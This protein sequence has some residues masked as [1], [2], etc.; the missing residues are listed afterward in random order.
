MRVGRVLVVTLLLLALP[1]CAMLFTKEVNW[2]P[3]DFL[4]AGLLFGATG[5]A[6]EW[7]RPKLGYSGQIIAGAALL[8]LLGLVWA[9]LAVGIVD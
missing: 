1:A 5:L 9:Q 6:Y 7:L 8:M 2:G 3:G 4:I